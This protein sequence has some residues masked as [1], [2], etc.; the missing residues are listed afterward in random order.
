MDEWAAEFEQNMLKYDSL[1]VASPSSLRR[2]SN[3]PQIS[4]MLNSRSLQ[5]GW[6]TVRSNK[7]PVTVDG[8]HQYINTQDS[9]VPA[10]KKR[11]LQD[12]W[13]TVRNS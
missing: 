5:D 10:G 12:G 13:G 6:G 7:T 1:S 2:L 3:S 11:F 4:N 8:E 9:Y